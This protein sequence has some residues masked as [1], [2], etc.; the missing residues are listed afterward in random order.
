MVK[1]EIAVNP[2]L[3]GASIPHKKKQLDPKPKGY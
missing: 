2:F 3:P 1:I